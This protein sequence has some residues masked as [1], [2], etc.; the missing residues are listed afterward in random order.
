MSRIL[1]TSGP[2]REYIDPVRFLS[3]ASSGQM[4]A[5]LAEA[6]LAAGDDVVIVSGPVT[7]SYP[8]KSEVISV[9]STEEMLRV[10]LE[11]FPRCDGVVAAAAPC[12]F[13]PRA[14]SSTKI[15]RS[16][17]G[18]TLELEETPD[19][20]AALAGRR[21][22][23]W[24]VA[25]ALESDRPRE[26]ALA[27]LQRKGADLIVVN[28]P[29]AI[30]SPSTALEVLTPAGEVLGILAGSKKEVARQLIELFT[31]YFSAKH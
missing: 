1:I 29:D 25:F 6:F 16:G 18:L 21:T 5:A 3:N 10:C 24:I 4:G 27:K 31:R 28:G 30:N 26:N 22:H 23:Q 14:F 11:Q 13:R 17:A 9:I 2:T 15:R 12:D 8:V 20:V 19:I 7:V